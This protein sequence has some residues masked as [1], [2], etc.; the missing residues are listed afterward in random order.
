MKI[1]HGFIFR[2]VKPL[3]PSNSIKCLSKEVT[4]AESYSER[5]KKPIIDSCKYK[6]NIFSNLVY[7]NIIQET[8]RIFFFYKGMCIKVW[9]AWN[10]I[11]AFHNKC[12]FNFPAVFSIT[13][14]TLSLSIGP[15]FEP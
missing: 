4:K 15:E 12:L 1:Q 3:A 10:E 8:F 13:F 9:P 5:I 6:N 14:C 7:A 2:S 11:L